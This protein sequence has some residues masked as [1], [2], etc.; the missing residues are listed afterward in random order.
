M[1]ATPLTSSSQYSVAVCSQAD[2]GTIDDVDSTGVH[3]RTHVLMGR[4]D[5]KVAEAVVVEVTHREAG[6]EA[7]R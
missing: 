1:P 5:G 2:D 7:L 6:S 4:A 3:S